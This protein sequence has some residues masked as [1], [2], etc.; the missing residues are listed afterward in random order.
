MT[1][2]HIELLSRFSRNVWSLTATGN[3]ERL[4]EVPSVEPELAK[5]AGTT[6]PLMCLPD[7]EARAIEIVRLFL[8]RGADPTARNQE[9]MMA[10]DLARK[11]GMNDLAELLK[12]GGTRAPATDLPKRTKAPNGG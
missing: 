7:D 1:P 11:R 2:P 4:R 10:A 8:A 12:A 9:G 3:V 6:T 5:A